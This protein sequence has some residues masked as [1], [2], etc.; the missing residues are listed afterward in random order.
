MQ[1]LQ[2]VA[3]QLRVD[4]EIA[5]NSVPAMWL[6]NV[7]LQARVHLGWGLAWVSSPLYSSP[8]IPVQPRVAKLL[9]GECGMLPLYCL[10]RE[11]TNERLLQMPY[12][13]PPLS[14]RVR[15][16]IISSRER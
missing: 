5:V 16:Y 11:I 10:D 2:F 12:Y 9:Q 15:E 14:P 13:L 4:F 7:H 1:W 3:R 6:T 8:D